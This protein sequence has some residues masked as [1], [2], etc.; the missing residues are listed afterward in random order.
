MNVWVVA[1]VLVFVMLA[2]TLAV[3]ALRR[4]RNPP[5]ISVEKSGEDE[6]AKRV[7][8]DLLER[9]GSELLQRRVDLD[10]RRGTLGGN[11]EVYEA[12]E[13]LEAQLRAGTISESE[14]EQEKVRLLGG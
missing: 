3:I 12:F 5:T 1:V 10:A 8:H 14:F 2:G 9:R 13:H 6:A 7:R 11:T 4:Q